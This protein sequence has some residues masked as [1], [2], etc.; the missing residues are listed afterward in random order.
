[1]AQSHLDH[2]LSLY[3]DGVLSPGERSTVA[4]HLAG[5]PACRT[6]LAELQGVSRLVAELPQRAP[7]RSLLPRRALVPRWLAPARWASSAAAAVFTLA[8]VV[9]SLPV[10][11]GIPSLTSPTAYG[12]AA[13]PA[14]TQS[15]SALTSADQ[16]AARQQDAARKALQ[17]SQS[18]TAAP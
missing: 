7:R 17:A 9:T 3:L 5:C 8:F 14:A 18:P 1:M 10:G 4:A 2:D 6:R 11:G 15:E 16:E 13:A 12:P